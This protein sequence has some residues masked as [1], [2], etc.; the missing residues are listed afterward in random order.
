MLSGKRDT[1]SEQGPAWQRL[2]TSLFE[3]ETDTMDYFRQVFFW[4]RDG[5]L[6]SKVNPWKDFP[7]CRP[8]KIVVVVHM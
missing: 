5:P 8:L 2:Y 1:Y 6:L 3:R 7:K 4:F